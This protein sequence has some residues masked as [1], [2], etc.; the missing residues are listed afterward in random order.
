MGVSDYVQLTAGIV[1]TVFGLVFGAWRL[2][3]VPQNQNFS[4]SATIRAIIYLVVMLAGGIG[5]I[6]FSFI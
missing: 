6:V 3:K 5:L 1:I 2:Y 4:K